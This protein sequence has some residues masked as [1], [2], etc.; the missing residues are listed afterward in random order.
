VA[1]SYG[2]DD[3]HGT[4]L[5]ESIFHMAGATSPQSQTRAEM[6]KAIRE[7]GREPLQRDT[8]YEAVIDQGSQAALASV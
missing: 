8:F 7:A 3:L 1:L 5:E 2:A 4:I 6:I